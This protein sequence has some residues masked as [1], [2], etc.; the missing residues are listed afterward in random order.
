MFQEIQYE[1]REHV[2]ILTLDRPDARNA[3]THATYAELQEAV[4]KTT[5][6]C[7]IVTGRDPAFC[8]GD[9]VKQVLAKAIDPHPACYAESSPQG[10]P[11]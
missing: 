1:E 5:A 2:G 9:D 11:L 8:S 4:E 3:L 10:D 7:L 6:R